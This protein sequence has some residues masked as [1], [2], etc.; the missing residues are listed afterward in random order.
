MSI[1]KTGRHRTL[2]TKEEGVPKRGQVDY[3]E[4][5]DRTHVAGEF[6]VDTSETAARSGCLASRPLPKALWLALLDSNQAKG[7][8]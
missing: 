8:S 4:L 7:A 6:C 3:R 2:L 5:K 1:S